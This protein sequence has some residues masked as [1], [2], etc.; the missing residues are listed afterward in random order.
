M[1]DV[2]PRIDELWEREAL[3]VLAQYIAIP[4]KSPAFDRDWAAHGHMDAAVSLVEE[5]MRARP[6]AGLTVERHDLPGRTPLL[7]AEIPGT[8]P[9]TVVLYGHVDKQPEMV[10]WRDGL[11]PWTAVREDDRL[12]G[13]GAADDGYAAFAAMGAIEAALA[14]GDPTPR[15]VVL[16][17]ASE[18]S[19]S[20]DLPAYMEILRDRI[21]TPDLVIGLDS[22]CA[23][24]DRLWVS[25]S[26][27]G[28]ASGTLRVE[29]L[30]EGVHSGL[31]SGVAPSVVRIAR[32][33]LD[34]IEDPDTGELKLPEL[35]GDIPPAV[36][37][38]A[39]SLAADLGPGV[40]G[41][42]PFVEGAHPVSDDPV[43]LILGGTWLPQLAVIGVDG[44]PAVADAG[45]VLLPQVTLAL[46]F[47][48]P[49]NVDPTAANA[50]IEHA[51]T[52]DPPY[53]ARV[54]YRPTEGCDGWAAPP[55]AP[56]L[57]AALDEASRVAFGAPTGAIGIGGTIPFMAMLGD[58]YPSAQFVITGVLGPGSNA[59]GP[60]EFL[61]VPTA[62]R[63]TAAVA[64]LLR[65]CPWR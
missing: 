56:W 20:P 6:I 8:A 49:P 5:W 14:T 29:V 31:G 4:N 39:E 2:D 37:A 42:L 48:L 45:N 30:T 57:E 50:A 59:H 51:L 43:Q 64:H 10:G 34:R 27:R 65:A 36:R 38:A 26:L 60:N 17:E 54:T 41:R 15:C 40:M 62:K 23:T 32:R 1:T 58:A 44:V 7:L 55:T 24:Y 25:T 11:A 13:R 3:P 21:G 22:G 19:G 12:Y 35:Y 53:G 18:E 52:A 47:R 46:S 16:I 9:G 63:L 28:M 33:L 61:H